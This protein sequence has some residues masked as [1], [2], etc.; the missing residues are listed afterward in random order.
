MIISH[1][2]I[3]HIESQALVFFFCCGP[4]QPD[5]SFTNMDQPL[6]PAYISRV[7]DEITNPFPNFLLLRRWSLGMDK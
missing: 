7:W 4:T 5:A 3:F 2:Y 6:I 1:D